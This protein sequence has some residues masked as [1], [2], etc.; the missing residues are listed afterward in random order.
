[1]TMLN[2]KR[3]DKREI[4]NFR[5]IRINLFKNWCAHYYSFRFI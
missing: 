3:K 2:K 1:M 5:I 4:D